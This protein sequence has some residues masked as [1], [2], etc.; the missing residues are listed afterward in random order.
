MAVSMNSCGASLPP[1]PLDGASIMT[2]SPDAPLS[3]RSMTSAPYPGPVLRAP[4]AS[5][6]SISG[7]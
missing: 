5:T 3:S 1:A 4:N 7:H 6:K 2:R